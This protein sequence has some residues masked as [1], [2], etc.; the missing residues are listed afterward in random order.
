MCCHR[1]SIFST[2]IDHDQPNGPL[3]EN[4]ASR[5]RRRAPLYRKQ[6]FTSRKGGYR[7]QWRP[8]RPGVTSLTLHYGWKGL[9]P[10]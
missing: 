9:A 4:I 10:R 2:R 6:K 8:W 7:N 5:V 3:A 1:A